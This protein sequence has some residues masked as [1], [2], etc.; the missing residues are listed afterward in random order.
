MVLTE[1]PYK[2]YTNK[3]GH[4]N[5]FLVVCPIAQYGDACE[6]ACGHCLNKTCSISDGICLEGCSPGFVG[7]RCLE[8][9]ER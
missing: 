2:S 1:H 5:Y 9:I 6:Y 3:T 4:N 8:G 7:N